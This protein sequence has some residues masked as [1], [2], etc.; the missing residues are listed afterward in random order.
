[1]RFGVNLSPESRR[2][3]DAIIAARGFRGLS[4]VIAAL[5]REEYER[6][7]PPQIHEVPPPYKTKPKKENNERL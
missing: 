2:R 5:I 4:D 7:C 1:M 6:R 3:A